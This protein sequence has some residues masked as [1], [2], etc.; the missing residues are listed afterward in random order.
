MPSHIT[1]ADLVAVK[2]RKSATLKHIFGHAPHWIRNAPQVARFAAIAGLA[3]VS[4]V[5]ESLLIAG[6]EPDNGTANGVQAD[7]TA[8]AK[9]KALHVVF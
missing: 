9:S 8:L 1:D 7:S 2:R 5:L 4:L 3:T 6:Q